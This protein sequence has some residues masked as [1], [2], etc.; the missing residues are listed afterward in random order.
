[1]CLHTRI[2]KYIYNKRF[3]QTNVYSLEKRNAALDDSIDK[4]VLRAC[5]PAGVLLFACG[6]TQHRSSVQSVHNTRAILLNFLISRALLRDSDGRLLLVC[7]CTV[8]LS[9]CLY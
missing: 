3:N 6:G 5:Y 8:F 7:L 1:M 9:I 2:T 4:I